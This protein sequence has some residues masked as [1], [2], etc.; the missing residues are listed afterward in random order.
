MNKFLKV[1]GYVAGAIGILIIGLV[2]FL[3]T[4]FPKH[5]ELRDLKV[6]IT[7]ARV[8][9]GK[10]LAEE[11]FLCQSCHSPR[12]W[13]KFAGPIP[14]GKAYIGG[15]RFDGEFGVL[16]AANLTPA[17]IGEMTDG[18][19]FRAITEGIK[20]DGSPMFP[21]MPYKIYKHQSEEDIYSVIAFL[22]TLAPVENKVEPSSVNFPLNL[23]MRT[24]PEPYTPQPE[25][26]KSTS[27][28]RGKYLAQACIYCH[29][30]IDDKGQ[31]LLDKVAGGGLKFWM[32]N[33]KILQS[34]N[35]SPDK[36]TGIGSWTKEQFIE[37]F[38][39]FDKPEIQNIYMEAHVD[40]T[41]MPWIEFSKMDSSKLGDI[42]DY[43]HSLSPVNHAVERYTGA[44][45]K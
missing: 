6:E 2:T 11:V 33:G 9:H 5:S 43:L 16:H 40:N 37:R 19:L 12:D 32:P 42:Y 22:R 20:R 26:D 31:Q 24:I 1:V 34:R 15:E 7:P 25:F 30:P 13:S 35:I 10:F 17:G 39:S 27:V 14:D 23:I 18:Q 8:E 38:K 29:T 28:N 3:Y 36:E 45:W 21:V 41:V 4:A 44:N